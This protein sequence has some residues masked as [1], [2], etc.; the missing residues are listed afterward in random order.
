M[1]AFAPRV[2][3]PYI[4][5][6]RATDQIGEF[7]AAARLG[8][9]WLIRHEQSVESGGGVAMIYVPDAICGSIPDRMPMMTNEIIS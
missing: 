9:G 1:T 7:T 3:V 2:S 4:R 8:D 5:W 6:F